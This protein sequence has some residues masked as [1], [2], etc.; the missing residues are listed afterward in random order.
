MPGLC[1][2]D[3]PEWIGCSCKQTAVME[4]NRGGIKSPLVAN[5]VLRVIHTKVF[6]LMS[7]AGQI[8]AQLHEVGFCASS[9]MQKLIDH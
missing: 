5:T 3:D 2:V 6:H 8:V 1:G 7:A 9:G 4:V